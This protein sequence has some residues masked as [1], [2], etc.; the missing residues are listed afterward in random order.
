[1]VYVGAGSQSSQVDVAVGVIQM[2]EAGG[3]AWDEDAAAAG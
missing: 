2:S 3:V 1:V